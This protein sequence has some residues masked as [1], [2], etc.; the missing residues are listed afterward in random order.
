M[1]LV[2]NNNTAGNP[3]VA[4]R[5]CLVPE[6]IV[7]LEDNNIFNPHIL[8][9]VV[10]NKKEVDRQ[11]LPVSDLM[12]YISFN[13][14]G[15]N[16]VLATIVWHKDG[17][18][19]LR[20]YYIGKGKYG[21][22][23]NFYNYSTDTLEN[24]DSYGLDSLTVNISTDFFAPE[25]PEWEKS[26][27]NLWFENKPKDQ[28]QFRKR[29]I[30][31]YSIQPPLILLYVIFLVFWRTL[32]ALF[33][34]VIRTRTKVNFIPIIHP[35]KADNEDVWFEAERRGRNIFLRDKNFSK[36]NDY[37]L[38]GILFHPIAVIVFSAILIVVDLTIIKIF[39]GW[40]SYLLGSLA[41]S[42]AIII[43][44]LIIFVVGI[45]GIWLVGIFKNWQK[46]SSKDKHMLKM[47]R[48]KE[49]E[50]KKSEA[51]KL[52]NEAK[53]LTQQAEF[54][55]L[56]NEFSLVSCDNGPIIP[57]LKALPKEKRTIHLRFL[58]LKARVCKPFAG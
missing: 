26:W 34:F 20:N 55:K 8:L 29:R 12:T 3:T 31:A 4:L 49:K 22:E 15:N 10:N 53:K 25:P 28:C 45:V 39:L 14:S 40:W 19:K 43:I 41:V 13:H 48:Q 18:K 33:W 1:K 11:L 2:A 5:W 42:V 17:L 16:T 37:K 51:I 6:D 21:Y 35:F 36:R 30:L 32:V 7:Y 57:K 24:T 38:A 56:K 52:A 44:V 54:D 27:V 58:D 47:R 46:K 9:I 23:N 50:A